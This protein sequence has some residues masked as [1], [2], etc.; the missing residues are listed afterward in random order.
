MRGS[1][2]YMSDVRWMTTG[3]D[4]QTHLLF[5]LL[6]Q[7]GSLHRGRMWRARGPGEALPALQA[8]HFVLCVPQPPVSPTVPLTSKETHAL[9][10]QTT[11]P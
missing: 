1:E 3:L 10:L 7:R 4:R 5:F 11:L 9:S 8:P 2:V 6:P